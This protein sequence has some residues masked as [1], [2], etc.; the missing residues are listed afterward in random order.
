VALDSS[1][2]SYT[3]TPAATYSGTDSFTYTV[4][5]QFSRTATGTVTITVN[6]PAAPTAA[7]YTE[8][9]P[10][11][12]PLVV[13]VANGVASNDTGTGLT[14]ALT[15]APAH[16]T[17][18]VN[19]DG[20]YTYTPTATYSGTDSFTYTATDA[21]SR[22]ATGTVTITVHAPT[23][24]TAANYTKST[25]FDTPL[26]VTVA[27]GVA[28]NDTGTGLTYALTGAPAHGTAVVN[29]D[30]SYTYTPTAT[31]SGTDSFTYTATD[32][33][34]RTAT[35]T[36]TIDV[37]GPGLPTPPSAADYTESTPYDTPLVVTGADGVLC[38]DTGDG[39]TLTSDTPALHGTVALDLSDGSYTYTPDAAFSGTDSFTYTV[40]DADHQ[41]ATGI[42]TIDV[43]AAS[44]PPVVMQVSPP[45]GPTAGGTE[46]DII[47]TG[48]AGAT[49]VAW[50]A[51][52]LFAIGPSLPA[53]ATDHASVT[54][55]L[56]FT[57]VS[58]TLITLIAPA[59]TGIVNVSLTTPLGTSAITAADH[60]TYV[61]AVAITPPTTP[62][63][64]TTPTATPTAAPTPTATTPST[65]TTT[66]TSPS[67]PPTAQ[68]LAPPTGSSGGL[69]F[70]GLDAALLSFGG[71]ALLV[72]GAF[73]LTVTRRS[74]K[75][76]DART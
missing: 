5:D 21:D 28:S 30:G 63:T 40:T 73:L 39:L 67:N 29:A 38:D 1:D 62:T 70:T 36:V 61:A 33:F 75:R 52:D 65:S 66:T 11:D 41:T 42:V 15:G 45:T 59:G 57:L 54:P 16:G 32:Q 37:A 56:T 71:L 43:A 23:A 10:F 19:A 17:V 22:T 48:F 58:P 60:F 55:T 46:V 76:K 50:G 6:T 31:Y 24:P 34:N 14:Y 9:T 12:T 64:P 68:S 53:S 44:A 25:P 3:Y 8:S 13:T 47:G 72:A 26:V 35:G 7:D 20:S 51:T 18:V 27:D 4:T 49:E 2:G 74:R 69:A